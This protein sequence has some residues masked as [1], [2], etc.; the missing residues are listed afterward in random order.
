M[1]RIFQTAA[2]VFLGVMAVL[3]VRALPGWIGAYRNEQ[4]QQT[5]AQVQSPEILIS[6][7]GQPINDKAE[8]LGPK[9]LRTL[10]YKGPLGD[11]EV[12]FM[13]TKDVAWHLQ[14]VSDSAETWTVYNDKGA[15]AIL[16]NLPCMGS[17]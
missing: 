16:S 15:V 17:H 12:Q 9:K 14:Q 7:C 8:E 5:L 4:R 3:F 6:R 11:V 2:G 13:A 10:T 1:K